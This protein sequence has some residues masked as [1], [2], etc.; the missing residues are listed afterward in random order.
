MATLTK[1]T[2]RIKGWGVDADPRNEPTYP[3]KNYTGDD[4]NRLN[5]EKP[6]SQRKTIDVLHSNER[7]S[8]TA[9]YGT[10]APLSGISGL[11]RRLAFR[12]SESSFG[13]W[14]P[15]IFADR[16]NIW[17]G[18]LSDFKR[19]FIPNIF[20]ER[21]LRAELKYNK[22]QFLARSAVKVLAAAFVVSWILTSSRKRKR[23]RNW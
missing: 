19:G 6:E 15:L 9:V 18:F 13:H 5:Y 12:Y 20:A 14:L 4:H 17:E 8:E 1:E 10:A 11:L 7:P 21:G 3:M 2:T 23:K 16:I 22:K